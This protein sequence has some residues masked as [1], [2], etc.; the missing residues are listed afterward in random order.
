MNQSTDQHAVR[1]TPSRWLEHSL[2]KNFITLAAIFL[3]FLCGC[4][5]S[6]APPATNSS[7]SA[8]PTSQPSNEVRLPDPSLSGEIAN[9][10]I[11]P[12]PNNTKNV[13]LTIFMSVGNT[14]SAT[15]A[16][17][18]RLIVTTPGREDLR[19]LQPVHVNGIVGIPGGEGQVDLGKEDLALKS[20]K[21][22]IVKD[23]RLEGV[24]TFILSD[25][26][27][28]NISNNSSSFVV[29]FDD[30]QGRSYQTK[31]YVIGAKR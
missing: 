21:T 23:Y 19:D 8:Q 12:V 30:S 4:R 28:K 11:Y 3:L 5:N 29:K 22:L 26:S 17:N 10:S 27:E 13:A 31:K 20:K 18:W 15:L 6:P 25:T 1:A 7:A 16:Q 24:L 2:S 14:G 9:L